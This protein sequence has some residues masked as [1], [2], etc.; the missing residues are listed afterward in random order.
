MIAQPIRQDTPRWRFSFSPS[1]LLMFLAAVLTAL[2]Y[3]PLNHATH[4]HIL[5]TA[6]DHK[7]P[8]IAIFAVPYLLLLLAFWLAMVYALLTDKHYVQFALTATIVF[9]VSDIIFATFHTYAPRPHLSSG[10][11]NN[12]VRFVYDHDHP[13]NDL[14]S[15]HA[16]MA[17]MLAL[18]GY[19]LGYRWRWTVTAFS[20]SV[21][22]A[23][24][25]I[26][27]HTI[28]GA[29]AGVVLAA[30]VWLGV[31]WSLKLFGSES[32]IQENNLNRDRHQNASTDLRKRGPA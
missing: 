7:L 11:F 28:A 30:V 21:V 15:G 9:L 20:V 22:L 2:A 24:L 1:R 29:S 31:D 17:T 5:T 10:L 13:Y 19:A 14:P 4:P 3:E 32:H 6:L 8:V 12:F 18:Y 16:A 26:K 27:Q 25:F 23:T